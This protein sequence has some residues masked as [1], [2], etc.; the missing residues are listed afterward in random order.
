MYNIFYI[1]EG[2][3]TSEK[4][5][6]KKETAFSDLLDQAAI[7]DKSGIIH[8]F[9]IDHSIDTKTFGLILDQFKNRNSINGLNK[10]GETILHVLVYKKKTDLIKIALEKGADPNLKPNVLDDL[11]SPFDLFLKNYCTVK[12]RKTDDIAQILNTILAFLSFNG[13][14]KLNAIILNYIKYAEE[15]LFKNINEI[16]SSITSSPSPPS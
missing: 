16:K 11:I 5:N 10:D 3:D 2:R 4:R 13:K 9:L 6:S 12:D 1:I 15:H 7:L 14:T 8:Q